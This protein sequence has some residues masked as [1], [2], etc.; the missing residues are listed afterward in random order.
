[1]GE[2]PGHLGYLDVQAEDWLNGRSVLVPTLWVKSV[3][4]DD[5]WVTLHH[6]KDGI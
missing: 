2:A 1:M 4:W 6:S 3:F 5:H